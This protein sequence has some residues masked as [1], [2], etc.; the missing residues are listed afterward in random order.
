MIRIQRAVSGLPVRALRGWPAALLLATVSGSAHAE[1]FYE[2]SAKASYN[3]NLSNA[4]S[5]R[6]IESDAAMEG[7]FSG[8]RYWQLTDRAGLAVTADLGGVRQIDFTGLDHLSMGATAS[9]RTKLGLGAEAPWVRIAGTGTR[10]EYN[11]G[12]RDGWRYTL[13]IEAGKRFGD[14][15]DLHLRY[16]YDNRLTDRSVDIPFL[17]STFGVHGDAFDTEGHS[18][19][20][21]GVY[22]LTDRIALLLDYTRRQ[23]TV[24]STTRANKE[25][26]DA[27]DAITPDIVFGLDRFAYRVDVDSD[28]ISAGLSWAVNEHASLNAIYTYQNSGGYEDV[29]YTNNIVTIGLL[30]A[31]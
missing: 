8:G 17:V 28:I 12:P 3:D 6:D 11:F 15:L 22:T 19:N 27:S 29:T 18:L 9:L 2:A 21:G 23:G 20:V 30:Y 1:W 7:N 24:T 10:L 4:S 16:T 31:Y 14:R 13:S 5:S 25:I 26:F